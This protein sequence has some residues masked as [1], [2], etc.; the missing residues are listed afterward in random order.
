VGSFVFARVARPLPHPKR[1]GLADAGDSVK[2]EVAS[3]AADDGG[4]GTGG[5]SDRS[6]GTGSEVSCELSNPLELR[7]AVDEMRGE[8]NN[9]CEDVL[10]FTSP[11][12]E[13]LGPASSDEKRGAGGDE[14]EIS[15]DWV[16]VESSEEVEEYCKPD[17]VKSLLTEE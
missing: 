9:P 3:V 13:S 14:G 5:T 7:E 15:D 16:G 1:F 4:T 2:L 11:L 8:G 6:G 12:A 17:E 10:S